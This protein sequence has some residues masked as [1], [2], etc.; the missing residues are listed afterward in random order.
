MSRHGRYYLGR[1][2]KLGQLNQKTLIEAIG[3]AASVTVGKF[4]WTITDVEDKTASAKKYIYGALSKYSREGHVTVVNDK[5]NSRVDA[6]AKNLL[7]ASSPFVY[8]PDYSGLAFLHV[9]N[10]I[11]E[12]LFP[13]RFKAVIEAT[14]KN[15]FVD[16]CLRMPINCCFRQKKKR[17]Y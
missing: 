11:Q 8:L 2:I 15:F 14:H 16:Y 3:N 9:W 7:V 4:T 5:T 17:I 1:V 6:I 12:D 10:H 13:R